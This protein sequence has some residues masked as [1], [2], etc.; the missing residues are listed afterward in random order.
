MCLA[1][2]RGTRTLI[3]MSSGS[4]EPLTNPGDTNSQNHERDGSGQL[5]RKKRRID[6]CEIAVFAGRVEM[7]NQAEKGRKQTRSEAADDAR[8]SEPQASRTGRAIG[9]RASGPPANARGT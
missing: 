8:E 7:Q 2:Q 9:C 6:V 1:S 5:R 4:Q 3:R